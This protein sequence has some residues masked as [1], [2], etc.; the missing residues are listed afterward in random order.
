MPL[1]LM[2]STM[3]EVI[4]ED[5]VTLARMQGFSERVVILRHAARNALLPVATA[6]ALG[7]GYS[8]AWQCRGRDG[9]FLARPRA[10]A[11]QGRAGA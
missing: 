11:R 6:F 2:R 4:D 1:L 10:A 9:L 5:F 3:I 7:I 8:V